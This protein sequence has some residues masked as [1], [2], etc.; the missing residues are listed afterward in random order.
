MR[1]SCTLKRK[2]VSARILLGLAASLFALQAQAAGL[3]CVRVP[4][5]LEPTWLENGAWST[6]G[7]LLVLSDIFHG[8]LLRFSRGG[9]RLSDISAPG[10]GPLEFNQPWE[11]FPTSDGF[12]LSDGNLKWLTLDR[13]ARPKRYLGS[14]EPWKL[15]LVSLALLGDELLGLGSANVEK[16]FR[17]TFVR[18]RV[19]SMAVLAWSEGSP[20]SDAEASY[21]PALGRLL[22]VAD[23][24]AYAV[25]L[26]PKPHLE[27]LFPT[28]ILSSFPIG[29]ESPP[30]VPPRATSPGRHEELEA[31]LLTSKLPV[32]L[33]GDGKKLYLLSR[34]PRG[35]AGTLWRLHR[36]DPL[37]DR[38]EVTL[39]LPTA[40]PH[41]SLIPGPER[42]ALL[43]QGRVTADVQRAFEGMVLIPAAWIT[44]PGSP[45]E[46]EAGASQCKQLSP[47][48]TNW[49]P[50]G[51]GLPETN[52]GGPR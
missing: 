37:L 31:Y 1:S 25:R 11:L 9:E 48:S 8:R 24:K 19:G 15:G 36:I 34:E 41:L 50:E 21:Y 38:L 44:K 12:I 6:S 26:A 2:L 5:Q 42:W 47:K 46:T 27:Q 28:R 49:R 23:D 33:L 35:A 3:E 10:S 17:Q 7:E 52:E 40:A 16:K 4:Q 29:F 45:L 51:Q 22:A 39:F 20:V 30:K 18:A 43:S 32:S 14:G 13:D